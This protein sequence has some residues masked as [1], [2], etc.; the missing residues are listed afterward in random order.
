MRFFLVLILSALI[1]SAANITNVVS[2]QKLAAG[3]RVTT[4]ATASGGGGGGWTPSTPSNTIK[5]WLRP[6]E[7]STSPVTTWTANVG[8]NLPS[9]GGTDPTRI[10]AVNNGQPAVRFNGTDNR[11]KAAFG[12]NQANPYT[13][14]YILRLQGDTT[15]F[16]VIADGSSFNNVLRTVSSQFQAYADNVTDV[17][18][19]GATDTNW[20]VMLVT[21]NGASGTVQMDGGSETTYNMGNQVMDGLTLG[22]NATGSLF[23]E[24]DVQEVVVW[25]GVLSGPDKS[26]WFSYGTTSR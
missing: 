7:L 6:E 15:S 4:I 18:I 17:G 26:G 24:C 2:G 25:N 20:H 16:T 8:V 13:I 23:R 3:D 14:G 5:Q 21:I 12:S 11:M 19:L 22:G 10:T 9:V 1:G